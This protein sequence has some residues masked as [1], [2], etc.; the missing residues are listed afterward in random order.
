L[1]TTDRE[2]KI[3]HGKNQIYTVSFHKSSSQRIID[4]KPNSRRETTPH[5]KKESNLLSTNQ[6]EYSHTNIKIT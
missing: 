4:G 1:T 2:T 5:K 3:F 6:K